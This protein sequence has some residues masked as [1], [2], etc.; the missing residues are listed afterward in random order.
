MDR[1]RKTRPSPKHVKRP[2][3]EPPPVNPE[4]VIMDVKGRVIGVVP[5]AQR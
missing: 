1:K 3:K 5:L 2:R 4:D